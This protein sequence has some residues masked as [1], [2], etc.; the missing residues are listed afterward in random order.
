[1]KQSRYNIWKKEENGF[2]IINTLSRGI[3][4]VN[5]GER[6][7]VNRILQGEQFREYDNYKNILIENGFLIDDNI[8]ELKN[9]EL[10]YNKAFFSSD[11]LNITLI[12]TLK[13]NFSCPYCFEY[14]EKKLKWRNSDLDSLIKFANN[15]FPKKNHVHISLFGGEPL[16]EYK[17]IKIFLYS[18]ND[19][20]N[21]TTSLT[22]NGYL[23]N[24]NITKELIENYNCN[25]FQITIDGP[26][27]KHNLT[28]KLLNGKGT[29]NVVIENF[30]KLLKYKIIHSLDYE[31]I[32]RINML[33]LKIEE[34]NSIFKYFDI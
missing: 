34:L 31:L 25:S 15:E 5:S 27:N 24:E 2:Y 20:I 9:L 12:P 8:D 16:L 13:C 30:I 23:I 3:I 7:I 21:Y 18:L 1:M 17:K 6:E 33:N 22:T 14:Q 26:E 19:N 32:L 4:W 11:I 10:Q 29:F 28:R